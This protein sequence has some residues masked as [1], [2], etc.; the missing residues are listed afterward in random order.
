[1]TSEL[2]INDC[3]MIMGRSSALAYFFNVNLVSLLSCFQR[4]VIARNSGHLTKL[5]QCFESSTA[6]GLGESSG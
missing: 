2:Y 1:M 5:L 3:L 6:D 4:C